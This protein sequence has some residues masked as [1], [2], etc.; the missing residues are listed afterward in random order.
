M[1]EIPLVCDDRTGPARTLLIT[2]TNT[3]RLIMVVKPTIS[4]RNNN[5]TL[6]NMQVQRFIP[7]DSLKLRN[8][9]AVSSIR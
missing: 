8:V 6:K 2:L 4:V 1:E 9:G 3:K 5:R 7:H